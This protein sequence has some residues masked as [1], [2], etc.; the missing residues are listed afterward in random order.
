MADKPPKRH[1][2]LKRFIIFLLFVALCIAAYIYIIEH[3]KVKTTIHQSKAVVTKINTAPKTK[4]YIEPDFTVDLPASFVTAAAQPSYR[5]YVWQYTADGNSEE[6][7]IYEDSIPQNI[8]LNRVVIVSSS[9]N[10]IVASS[11]EVSDNCS[12]YTIP[13]GTRYGEFGMLAKWQGVEFICDLS[14]T[15][16]DVVGTS[17]TDGINTVKV[18][19]DAAIS[20]K[21]FFV[22]TN[23]D[24][25]NADYSPLF[26]ALQSFAMN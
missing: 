17:S 8:G 23:T 9:D 22:L 16:R 25:S 19:D 1:R 10:R 24:F 15:E 18:T 5:D 2:K 6:L 3:L 11:G 20:H 4:H 7:V 12:Q 26:T 21:F 13:N 14:N